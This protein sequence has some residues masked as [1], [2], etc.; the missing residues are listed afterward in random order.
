MHN[1]EI[2]IKGQVTLFVMCLNN[3]CRNLYYLKSVNFCTFAA[4]NLAKIYTS[5]FYFSLK[6]K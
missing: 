5:D 3:I 2:A 4:L 1:K 6:I